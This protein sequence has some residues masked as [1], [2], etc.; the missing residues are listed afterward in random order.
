ME[1]SGSVEAM[2][3]LDA[4]T[5]QRL[6]TND[7]MRIDLAEDADGGIS[8]RIGN[9]QFHV[10]APA[11]SAPS[12]PDL[13][14]EFTPRSTMQRWLE[15]FAIVPSRE[16]DMTSRLV[17]HLVNR[18]MPEAKL[19]AEEAEKKRKEEEAEAD[20]KPEFAEEAAQGEIGDVVT[21]SAVPLP[22]SRA[23]P[24]PPVEEE[25]VAVVAAPE[26]APETAEAGVA[27]EDVD[28]AAPP[29]ETLA[30]TIIQINGSDVDITDTGIDIEFLQALPDDMRAEVVEQHLREHRPANTA[31]P[32]AASTIDP[33][34][35]EALPA[36]IRAELLMQEALE[37][38]RQRRPAAAVPAPAAPPPDPMALFGQMMEE[39]AAQLPGVLAGAEA[40]IRAPA[41]ARRPHRESLQ[42]LDK[43]GIA[44]LLRLLFFPESF[45]RTPLFNILV[46]LCENSTT[47]ADLLNLLLSVVQDGSG[48]LP[49]VDRSFQQMS[50][51]NPITPKATPRKAPETPGPVPLPFFA[52]LQSER[53]PTFIA[54][55][56]FEAL[57]AI[58]AANQQAVTFF[59]TEHE[60]AVGLK[61]P[62]SKKGKGK[63]LPQTK[64]PIV[65]LLGLL[66]RPLLLNSAAMMEPITNLLQTITRPLTSLRPEEHKEEPIVDVAEPSAPAAAATP[67]V[68]SA[69][70]ATPA[71]APTISEPAGLTKMPIIPN[72][73]LC[74]VVN[75]MTTAECSSRTFSN[76]LMLMQNLSSDPKSKEV[77]L[78]EICSRV[79]D[80]GRTI[81]GELAEL[82]AGLKG[83][84]VEATAKFS[85]SQAQLL[86]LLK[87]IDYLYTNKVDSD[88][89]VD[90]FSESEQKV[91]DTF[92]SFDLEAVWQG[93]GACLTE[94]A[95]NTGQL[96]T[97]LLPLVEALMV[98]CKYRARAEVRSP[99]PGADLFVSFTTAH[100]KV[101]N[102]IVRNNP[103]LLSGSFS[104]LVRNPK[105]LE[106][107]NKRNWFFQKLKR[108]R[109]AGASLHLNIRRQYVFED[110]FQAL[111]RRS[112]DEIKYGKL[113]VKF[114]NEDGIDA[115]GVTR[116]WYSVLARQIFD[117]NFGK[118]ELE[119][120]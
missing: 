84:G 61:K 14:A 27:V 63:V 74:L 43:N 60:Q 114:Y 112:G 7:P 29:E 100:R 39:V 32:E 103:S 78:Q 104:L 99:E 59:L 30:R 31:A 48:D 28:M 73:V 47:R 9:R 46:N 117:P 34:F 77:I 119:R 88:A 90:T 80:L 24:Q 120:H 113:N 33:Q 68:P 62:V 55:R 21:A 15:E 10:P 102:V 82:L 91:G 26:P 42:L 4:L 51:R 57:T 3:A 25:L 94:V 72:N 17:M 11:R 107:D 20:A 75:C 96:A 8:L 85:G 49:S 58:V 41:P 116:E 111:Q 18:M 108:K 6:H 22:E 38:A 76:T 35:L 12:Q 64:F 71:A 37:Q 79:R 40:V 23:T 110:S 19:L 67:A 5:S 97:V 13:V 101:L 45:K 2:A 86:R 70:T 98:I 53:I 83:E 65:I 36:H 105:V 52:H 92:A 50:L 109:E 54:Q 115:G 95:E 69:P 16:G 106:F 89:P 1:Q 81:Q 87:S 44:S 93:L 56:C 66:D 118:S